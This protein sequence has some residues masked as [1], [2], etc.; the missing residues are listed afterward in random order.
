MDHVLERMLSDT[1]HD[2]HLV[3]M[4]DDVC[5]LEEVISICRMTMAW[6]FPWR[7]G[8]EKDGSEESIL[9]NL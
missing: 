6:S 1:L 7:P 3:A 8:C 9:I 4:R 5:C 2:V